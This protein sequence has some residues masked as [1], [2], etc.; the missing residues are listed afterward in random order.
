[1]NGLKRLGMRHP[2]HCRMAGYSIGPKQVS[3]ASR[4]KFELF[5]LGREASCEK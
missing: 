3:C 2:R 1:M 5:N 4:E